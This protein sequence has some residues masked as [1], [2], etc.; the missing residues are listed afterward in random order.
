[1]LP[2]QTEGTKMSFGYIERTWEA[3]REYQAQQPTEMEE[4][5]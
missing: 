4:G 2:D 5:E 3:E 1:M